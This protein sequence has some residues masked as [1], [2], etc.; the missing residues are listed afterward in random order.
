LYSPEEIAWAN[1]PDD[2]IEVSLKRQTPS[3]SDQG[4]FD[5]VCELREWHGNETAI[6]ICDMWDKHWCKGATQRV[7]EMAPH[8]NEVVSI[9]RRMGVQI[10][11]A[12]SDCMEYYRDHPARRLG[13][14]YKFKAVEE[15]LGEGLLESEAGKEWPFQISGGGCD[16]HPQCEQGS[17]WTRQI[18]SIEILEGDI[19]TDS[20]VEAGSFFS[21][22]GIR[23]V[24]IMGVHTNMC[25]INR[26]FGLRNMTRLGLN[27]VLMRD[28]TDTMYNSDSWPFVSHFTG[29]RL[30]IE[31][32]EKYVCPTMLSSDFTGEEQFR[33]KE[34]MT[35]SLENSS[36]P[37][38]K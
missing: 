23:N 36:N 10:V 21:D 35:L 30:M 7:T 37:E 5:I 2:G 20:G 15:K 22:R 12:P 18:E 24:I 16:D 28:M 4:A 32:I 1:D 33:F 8:M 26:S 11:H 3:E 14:K 27:V 9:A 31:Y 34:D 29:T 25:V 13:Q 38:N 19:I 6:I 17:P